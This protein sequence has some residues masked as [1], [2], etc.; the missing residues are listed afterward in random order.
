MIFKFFRLLPPEVAHNLTI[1]LLKTG[2]TK[3]YKKNNYNDSTLQ[4]F[5]WNLEFRNPLG[6]AAGFD[7]NAEIIDPL[8]DLG[9]G[10]VEL[11]TVTPEPQIGNKKPRVFRLINDSALINHLGFNND[12]IKKIEKRLSYRHLNRYSSQGIIGINIG[13]N[14]FTEENSK[15]YILCLKALGKHVNYIVINISSPNTPGLRNLQNRENLEN[16][17]I[18]IKKEKK[19][20]EKISNKPLLI[21]ISPDLNNEEKRDIALTSLAQGIDGIIISNTTLSR[22][23]SLISNK[24]EE[25]G[26]LS[27]KPLYLISTILLKEMYALTGGKIPLIGVG[28]ISS[29]REAYEKIKAGASLLQLYTGLIYDGP[30]IIKKIN[31]ELKNLLKTDGYNNISQA[32]GTDVQ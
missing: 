18:S 17:I 5:I 24:K 23:K 3:F 1:K 13:K 8:L 30:Q 21:K 29:G 22:P 25:I 31:I 6:I 32:I 15:D 9:F 14:S 19:L 4:Q 7:K 20:D 11:G 26:G 2:I 27:G 12:G 28:G 16:L 10:F